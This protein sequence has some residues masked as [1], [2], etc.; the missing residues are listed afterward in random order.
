MAMAGYYRRRDR[1]WSTQY[2]E[3]EMTDESYPGNGFRDF[4]GLSTDFMDHYQGT[5]MTHLVTLP[6]VYGGVC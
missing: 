6:N 3:Y 2:P 1:A 5:I 4:G